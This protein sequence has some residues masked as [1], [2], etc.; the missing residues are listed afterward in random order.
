[1]LDRNT[2]Q[3]VASSDGGHGFDTMSVTKLF[4]A[5][6]YLVQADGQP[7]P[8]LT[9]ELEQ[10]ITQSDDSIQI[11]LWD[12][13]IVGFVADRYGLADT[14]GSGSSRPNNWGSDKT[15]ADDMVSFLYQMANDPLVGP[16]LL[17]WMSQTEATGIDGFD[18]AFG[19]NALTGDHG[20][21]Q[22]WSD[23]GFY[24]RILNSVGWTG[25][26]FVAIFERSDES[27]STMRDAA[28]NTA[29]LISQSR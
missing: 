21:K 23:D 9:A 29:T 1:M 2:G 5:T 14:Y 15:T 4:T 18:Q 26:Y 7:D 10:M 24:P 25:H 12:Y 3:I 16:R 17:S 22:G 20:S 13:D 27:F 19:L 6:Y 28:T 8:D 11:A